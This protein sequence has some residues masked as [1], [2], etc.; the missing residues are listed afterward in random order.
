MTVD[1][2]QIELLRAS[3]REVLIA[4]P[5]RVEPLLAE[6]GWDEVVADD[7]AAAARLLFAEHGRALGQAAALDTVVLPVLAAGLPGGADTVCYPCP[8]SGW[9]S[10]STPDQIRGLLLRAPAPDARV[11]A[12][13]AGTA[14]P[15]LAVVA[16]RE[17][18]VTRN[19]GIDPSLPWLEAT[20]PTP[21]HL[22]PADTWAPAVAA[23]HRGLAA[24]I[25]ATAEEALRLAVEHTSTRRQFGALIASF[26]AVRHRL[27]DSE[28]ALSAARALLDAAFDDGG[29]LSALVA[30]AEAGRAHQLVSAN[31]MQVCGAIGAT[32][33]HPL[34]R[35][36][37]RGLALDALLGDAPMLTDQLGEILF[38]TG[39]V[40]RL[41]EV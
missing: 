12:P 36:V 29:T 34:H 5:D 8:A 25:I 38:R 28:T 35:Y 41:V 3:V 24:E 27:A 33:E 19:A 11:V 22:H 31:A 9:Q 15:A 2:D 37:A 30:K 32:S 20:A 16:G 26:Q 40:P 4:E 23:A 13:V 7:E 21:A 6:L 14:G 39:D 18:S 1:Q 17:L 10:S